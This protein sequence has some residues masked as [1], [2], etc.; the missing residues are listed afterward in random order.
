M[1]PRE[2]YLSY[3]RRS[4]EHAM[5]KMTQVLQKRKSRVL[6]PYYNSWA[7]LSEDGSRISCKSKH[8]IKN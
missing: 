3:P 5:V 2:D 6:D 8:Q 4:D 7:V 1:K